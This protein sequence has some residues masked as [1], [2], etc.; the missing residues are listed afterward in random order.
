MPAHRFWMKGGASGR[1]ID[2]Y[3]S[4]ECDDEDTDGQCPSADTHE[5]A[6]EP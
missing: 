2:F 4:S 1:A 6:L 3:H 5:Q